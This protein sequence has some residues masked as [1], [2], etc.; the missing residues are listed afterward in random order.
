MPEFKSVTIPAGDLVEA[1]DGKLVIGDHPIIG[2]LRGDG[3]GI[4][5]TPGACELGSSPRR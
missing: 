5:I 4:D 3:I 1:R 2:V